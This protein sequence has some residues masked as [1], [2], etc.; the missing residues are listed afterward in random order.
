MD[1]LQF[2]KL[3]KD[4]KIADE[5]FSIAQCD[6]TFIEI[7]GRAEKKIT[8]NQ[9]KNSLERLA[10]KKG[11]TRT[12]ILRCIRDTRKPTYKDDRE[13]KDEIDQN[14]KK[15]GRQRSYSW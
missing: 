6:I 1:S 13:I 12:E 5:T 14:E 10:K 15:F 8:F 11:C 3:C 7:K 4:C 9:F 2:C